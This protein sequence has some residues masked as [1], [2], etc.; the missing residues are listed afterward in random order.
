MCINRQLFGT[1]IKIPL[2]VRTETISTANAMPQAPVYQRGQTN[3]SLSI[4]NV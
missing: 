3:K 2:L 4:E 1:F